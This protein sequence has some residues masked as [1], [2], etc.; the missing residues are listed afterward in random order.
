MQV[1]SNPDAHHDLWDALWPASFPP[2][3]ILSP[4]IILPSMLPTLM[5]NHIGLLP[6]LQINQVPSSFRASAV[7]IYSVWKLL[8]NSMGFLG[9]PD[10][11][12]V[13][14]SEG[15]P[16]PI[17]S[18]PLLKLIFLF[19]FPLSRCMSLLYLPTSF[20][21]VSPVLSDG[22]L[23][24]SSDLVC[25]LMVLS[26]MPRTGPFEKQMLNRCSLNP[27]RKINFLHWV[28]VL[29]FEIIE[30][31]ISHRWGKKKN[32]LTYLISPYQYIF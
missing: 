6:I 3:H 26:L 20:L 29:I 25:L 7:V 17:R 32:N 1:D 23:N 30:Y 9:C 14:F 19:A 31:I 21:S 16:W 28:L 22:Y 13:T 15:L 24:D 11:L 5:S 12:H 8:Y 2:T 18:S 4:I 10:Q 27:W